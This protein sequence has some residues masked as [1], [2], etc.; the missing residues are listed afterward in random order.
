M[1]C[2]AMTQIGRP[3]LSCFR[4]TSSHLSASVCPF[5]PISPPFLPRVV[6]LCNPLSFFSMLDPM[7]PRHEQNHPFH[8]RRKSPLDVFFDWHFILHRLVSIPRTTSQRH[9]TRTRFVFSGRQI[10]AAC[11]Y[12]PFNSLSNG[13]HSPDIGT[14]FQN[15]V[16]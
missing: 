3:L 6:G 14:A 16:F 9:I 10:L 13:N 5:F 1:E 2:H 15:T 7:G 11:P 4:L 12:P 8:L